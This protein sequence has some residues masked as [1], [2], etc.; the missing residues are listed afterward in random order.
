MFITRLFIANVT[1]QIECCIDEW[2]TGMRTDIS[3][4]VQDYCG[5]YDSHLK[6]LQEFDEV[7]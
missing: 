4:T 1:P 5:I 2:V 7:S 3:F 6:C